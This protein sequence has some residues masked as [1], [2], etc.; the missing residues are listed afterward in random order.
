EP[1]LTAV[2]GDRGGEWG[3]GGGKFDAGIEPT[4]GRPAGAAGAGGGAPRAPGD[5]EPGGEAADRDTE[6]AADKGGGE[7][8]APHFGAGGDQLEQ[9]RPEHAPGLPPNGC[10]TL[11]E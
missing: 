10:A 7:Q 5:G 3:G 6:K 4:E 9:F 2:I 8:R 1:D 11:A